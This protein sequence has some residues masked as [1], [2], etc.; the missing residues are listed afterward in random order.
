MKRKK[1]FTK[2]GS[3]MLALGMVCTMMPVGAFA[4]TNEGS[5]PIAV[6]NEDG[7]EERDGSVTIGDGVIQIENDL[8]DG[9]QLPADGEDGTEGADATP[10]PVPEPS[11]VPDTQQGET[12]T[13]EDDTEDTVTPTDD[14]TVS[15]SGIKTETTSLDRTFSVSVSTSD[16][17]AETTT[18]RSITV[19]ADEDMTLT[20]VGVT[21]ARE[22]CPAFTVYEYDENK[23]LLCSGTVENVQ[24]YTVSDPSARY[25]AIGWADGFDDSLI[26]TVNGEVNAD[27]AKTSLTLGGFLADTEDIAEE[28]GKNQISIAYEKIAM[29]APSVVMDKASLSY[30]EDGNI[31]VTGLDG[32]P[33]LGGKAVLTFSFGE[34]MFVDTITLP[35]FT[36]GSMPDIKVYADDALLV[37]S[38]DTIYVSRTVNSLKVELTKDVFDFVQDAALNISV[39]NVTSQTVTGMVDWAYTAADME[40]ADGSLTVDL[41]QNT[42]TEPKPVDPVEPT[43]EPTPIVTPEPADP[44][45]EPTPVIPDPSEDT[46]IDVSDDTEVKPA[47]TAEPKKETTL[48]KENVKVSGGDGEITA[49]VATTAEGARVVLDYTGVESLAASTDS[50]SLFGNASN[51]LESSSVSYTPTAKV[52]KSEITDVESTITPKSISEDSD[53]E[54]ATEVG[55]LPMEPEGSST[56]TPV[57]NNIFTVFIIIAVI[58]AGVAA[59]LAV[60]ILKKRKDFTAEDT[61]K[62]EQK[63]PEDPEK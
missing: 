47:P 57:T 1:I 28:Y 46:K 59:A 40:M 51:T 18:H 19:Q 63:K 60:F 34:G 37:I 52:E 38:G 4:A 24:T 11:G 58:L 53:T 22:E 27:T 23:A 61:K 56:G 31:T 13:E 7:Q 54:D 16:V 12:D 62:T 42:Q 29:P 20:S 21:S 15:L 35:T 49:L 14:G 3:T 39:R 50:V 41:I 48:T 25:I 26:L 8:D 32:N 55:R 9:S 36:E 2:L 5:I 44:T 30:L 33:K 10:A 17:I 6:E 45:P 43:P